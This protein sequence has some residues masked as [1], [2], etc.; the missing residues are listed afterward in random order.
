[1]VVIVVF[2][3][4]GKAAILLTFMCGVGNVKAGSWGPAGLGTHSP[5]LLFP[6]G[7]RKPPAFVSLASGLGSWI[8]A[9]WHLFIYLFFAEN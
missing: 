6:Q 2:R 7:P 1:M 4:E 8:L 5:P 3:A 9:Y